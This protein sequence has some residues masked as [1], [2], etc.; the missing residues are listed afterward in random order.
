MCIL[1]ASRGEPKYCDVWSD[2]SEGLAVSTKRVLNI[3]LMDQ[4]GKF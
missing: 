4:L 1:L 2:K 3:C